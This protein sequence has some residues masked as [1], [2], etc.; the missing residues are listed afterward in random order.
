[1]DPGGKPIR[2]YIRRFDVVEMVKT[3]RVWQITTSRHVL[4]QEV[5]HGS[6]DIKLEFRYSP[7]LSRLLVGK[8]VRDLVR[9]ELEKLPKEPK[10][11]YFASAKHAAK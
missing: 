1:V 9:I 8:K 6:K 10:G 7:K 2:A 3:R 4:R 11:S 5:Q